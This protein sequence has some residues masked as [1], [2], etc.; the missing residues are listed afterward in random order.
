MKIVSIGDGGNEYGMG[1]VYDKIL[2]SDIPFASEIASKDSCD[3]LLVSSISNCA[4]YA[5]AK[6][7][8]I[9]TGGRDYFLSDD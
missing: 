7:L 1:Y 4:S 8:E 9:L 3:F 5:I 6:Q 2:R